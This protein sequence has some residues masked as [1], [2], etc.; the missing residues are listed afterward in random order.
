MP[1]HEIAVEDAES[2]AKLRSLEDL[3]YELR[4]EVRRAFS[5]GRRGVAVEL[6]RRHPELRRRAHVFAVLYEEYQ[7]CTASNE[8]RGLDALPGEFAWFPDELHLKYNPVM[9]KRSL[10]EELLKRVVVPWPE[11]GDRLGGF[12]IVEQLGAGGAAQVYLAKEPALGDR[13]VAIKA[14]PRKTSEPETLGKLLHPNIVPVHSVTRDAP[15]RLTLVCMPF[16][17]RATLHDVCRQLFRGAGTQGAIQKVDGPLETRPTAP[18]WR[19]Q[20]ILDA[21]VRV[22]EAGGGANEA[23]GEGAARP[24]PMLAKRTYVDGVVHLAAQMADALAYTHAKDICHGDLKPANVLMTSGGRP[25]LLD[26]NLANPANCV[27]SEVG[28]TLVYMPPERLL[29]AATAREMASD[30]RSDV[31][32]LGAIVYQLLSGELP[33]GPL[34]DGPQNRAMAKWM[35]ERQGTRPLPLGVRNRD[36]DPSLATLVDRCLAFDAADRPQTARE[37]ASELRRHLAPARRVKRCLRTHRWLVTVAA[38]AL[39]F[40]TGAAAYRVV[41]A[42]TPA[43]YAFDKGM[44]AYQQKDYAAANQRLTES[45]DYGGKRWQTCYLRGLARQHLGD[46]GAALDD[47][48]AAK[49]LHRTATIKARIADCFARLPHKDVASAIGPFHGA[50]EDGLECAEMYNNL[51]VCFQLKSDFDDAR[52]CF[53]RAIALAPNLATPYYNRALVEWKLARGDRRSASA[54]GLHDVTQAVALGLSSPDVLLYAARMHGYGVDDTSRRRKALAY[55]ALAIKQGA[56]IERLNQDPTLAALMGELRARADYPELVAA[57]A[58][59]A[60]VPTPRLLDL[61]DDSDLAELVRP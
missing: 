26:F 40:A 39:I 15:T 35:W 7:L 8:E 61:P 41:N 1:L 59:C 47:Y 12:V 10:F 25:M 11:A 20:A 24:D 49:Q 13:L 22:N 4:R 55:L 43:E 60:A 9:R 50:I 30:P 16:L 37:L 45:L 52:D 36:I 38:A 3:V 2:P 44:A 21:I 56:K 5:Q 14:S 23:A 57:G 51:G 32:S 29:A 6:L 53:D 33:F 19:G 28:G 42:P 58:E 46:Y 27:D 18:P 48:Q 34:P 17:G 54:N 31:F